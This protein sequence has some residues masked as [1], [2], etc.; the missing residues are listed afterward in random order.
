MAQTGYWKYAAMAAATFIIASSA[1]AGE[2]QRAVRY[3]DLNLS[4]KS[5]Q[6]A[7]K[8]RVNSA[9]IGVCSSPLAKTVAERQDQK[10]CEARARTSAMRQAGEKIARNGRNIKVALD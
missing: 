4:T 8:K 2:R 9:V 7:L 1:S 6:A 3:D 10:Q 5:G